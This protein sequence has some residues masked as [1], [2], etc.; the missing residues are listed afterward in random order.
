MRFVFFCGGRGEEIVACDSFIAFV[1]P[2]TGATTNLSLSVSECWWLKP[3]KK[4]T[5]CVWVFHC[6]VWHVA[7]TPQNTNNQPTLPLSL[8]G[9]TGLAGCE[10]LIHNVIL[11]PL[12][13]G[14]PW[15]WLMPQVKGERS[16][17]PAWECRSW[18]A[19]SIFYTRPAFLSAA[20]LCSR[21]LHRHDF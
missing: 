21:H 8:S 15:W 7:G 3:E 17:A 18:P 4:K 11:L 16:A 14:C 9:C 12:S 6:L 10:V 20:G 1:W 2:V 13:H 19:R 5:S